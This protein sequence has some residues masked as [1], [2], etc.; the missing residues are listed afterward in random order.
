MVLHVSFQLTCG[1]R[2][3]TRQLQFKIQL[4]VFAFNMSDEF[5]TGSVPFSYHCVNET[6]RFV[7]SDIVLLQNPVFLSG[8]YDAVLQDFIQE[9]TD[10]MCGHLIHKTG[11]HPE[12]LLRWKRLKLSQKK[13]KCR[14]QDLYSLKIMISEE[15]LTNTKCCCPLRSINLRNGKEKDISPY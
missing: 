14:I 6:P 12:K 15:P 1:C 11:P 2:L 3:T 13:I 9:L 4:W 8:V 5:S 7:C 10:H